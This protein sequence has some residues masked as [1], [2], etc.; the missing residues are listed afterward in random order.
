[1]PYGGEAKAKVLKFPGMGEYYRRFWKGFRDS[2]LRSTREQVIGALLVFGILAFQ[3]L[4]G[5]VRTSDLRV[6]LLAILWPYILLL[7]GFVVWHLISVPLALDRE[8]KIAT[9]EALRRVAELEKKCFDEQPK[10]GIRIGLQ[11][12]DQWYEVRDDNGIMVQFIAEF[13]G[14]RV[15][16]DIRFDPV[17]SL[18]GAY[19]LNIHPMPFLSPNPPR[20]EHLGFWVW[21]NGRRPEDDMF[22]FKKTKQASWVDHFVSDRPQGMDKCIYSL[23]VRYKDGDDERVKRCEI[24]YATRMRF[25]RVR[26]VD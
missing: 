20:Y 3:V 8:R 23:V 5:V 10:F 24:E 17:I 1:L 19:W 16:T 26:E 9:D 14:G 11:A 13:L 15:P 25:F 12:G 21:V 2:F 4:L 7:L 6:N 22:A 18:K